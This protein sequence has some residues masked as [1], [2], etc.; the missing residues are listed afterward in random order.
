MIKFLN[1]STIHLTSQ[2]SYG[3]NGIKNPLKEDSLSV[4][5]TK[6]SAVKLYQNWLVLFV[7]VNNRINIT[8]RTP[9]TSY[10]LLIGH[11]FD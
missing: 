9:S 3:L 1:H 4:C 6:Y 7:S 8:A 11:F 2:I 5:I 10:I